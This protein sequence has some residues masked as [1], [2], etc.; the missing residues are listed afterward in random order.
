MQLLNCAADTNSGPM[1]TQSLFAET[2]QLG[3]F[4]RAEQN[5]RFD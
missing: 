1:V 3:Y 5:N 2:E 4:R